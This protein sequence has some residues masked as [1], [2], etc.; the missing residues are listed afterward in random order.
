VPYFVRGDVSIYYETKGSGFPLLTLPPGGMNATIE[1]WGRSAFNPLEVFS[2]DFWVIS[3]DQRNAGR[4]SG[5]LNM[6][7]PWGS[8]AEDQLGLMNHLGAER[9]HVLGCCIG[10]SFVLSLLQR[11]PERIAGA[12]LEQPIGIDDE[13]RDVL[14][15]NLYNRWAKA[16][17]EKHPEAGIEAAEAFGRKMC[18]GEFVLSVSRDFVKGCDKPLLVMPGSNLDHPHAT[19][20]EI[21]SLAR[22]AEVLEPWRHPAD[23]VPGAVSQIKRFLKEHT[24]A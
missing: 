12:V 17:V 1:W 16:Y 10:C 13:N 7:D 8:Y 22:N 21:A 19:G 15:G 2:H 5:P 9:F 3:M 4:S 20:M 6:D 11:N 23:V 14:P 24:P 18:S